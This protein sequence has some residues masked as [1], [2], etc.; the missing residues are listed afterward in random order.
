MTFDFQKGCIKFIRGGS[1]PH[2]HTLFIDD[3]IPCLID[4]S[5]RE[6]ILREIE[7]SKK[8]QV[9]ITS[10][11]H[12]DHMM[13]N[14]LFPKADLWVPEKDAPVFKDIRNL[15]TLYGITTEAEEAAWKEFLEKVCHYVP[16]KPDRLLRDGDI[17]DFGET[18]AEVIHTPG[19]TPGHCCFFFPQE[20]IIYLADLDL[21]N[22]GPY[23]G[24]IN[25]DLDQIIA[26]LRRIQKVE[27]D[28]YL[29]AHG[30]GIYE[31]NPG[32]IEKYLN[33]IWERE[34]RLLNL[35]HK[36]PMSL[37]QITREG[38]IYGKRDKTIQGLWDLSLSEKSMMKKHLDRL[39][40]KGS[41]IQQEGYYHLVE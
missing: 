41:L 4:A 15:I 31:G 6:D 11:G 5:S 8:I 18:H 35:L 16:R 9:I 37:E 25:S 33:K 39:K 22:A 12:E 10:H 7:S 28:T 40:R 30:K 34:E 13:Y 21:V 36:T 2:C 38:I 24:D 14:Y 20:S 1:Y 29:T 17:L 19:H 32:Y 26:S 3:R 23:Y 27:A